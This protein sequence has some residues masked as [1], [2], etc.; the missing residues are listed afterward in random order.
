MRL[1]HVLKSVMGEQTSCFVVTNVF[2]KMGLRYFTTANG[3]GECFWTGYSCV[4]C[5]IYIYINKDGHIFGIFIKGFSR[6][7][8]DATIHP[9][10][11]N[12]L[13]QFKC[14]K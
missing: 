13:T 6:P 7:S 12:L 4:T 10:V 3:G 5:N 1:Q 9:Q 8:E 14:H 11:I 2:V